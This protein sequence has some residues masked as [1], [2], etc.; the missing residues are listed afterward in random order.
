MSTTNKLLQTALQKCN[1]IKWPG[2]L[3]TPPSLLNHSKCSISTDLDGTEDDVLWNEQHD[4]SD[5]DSDGE[6]DDDI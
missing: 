3:S 2:I 6:M 4:K 1:T 5:T